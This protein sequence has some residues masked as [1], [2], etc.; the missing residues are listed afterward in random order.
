M[1]GDF[2][3]QKSERI[4]FAR[5]VALHEVKTKKVVTRIIKVRLRNAVLHSSTR[6]RENNNDALASRHPL[7]GLLK[8]FWG[9]AA[10]KKEE[11]YF[12]GLFF[13][14]KNK[15]TKT[16]KKREEIE[17]LFFFTKTLVWEC[18]RP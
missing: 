14:T 11:N 4:F 9:E 7:V 18:T 17:I 6:P 12:F 5:V 13:S 10:E 8:R 16:T 1:D 15:K 3:D 2:F